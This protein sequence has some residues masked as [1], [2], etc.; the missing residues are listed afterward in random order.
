[1]SD[2]SQAITRSGALLA[3]F[4][5]LTALLVAGTFVGTRD[6]ISAAERAAE[7]KALLQIMPRSLHDNS[8]LD[9]RIA[10]PAGDP[11][12][13]LP[14]ER[15]LYVARQGGVASAVLVPAVAPDGY[16]G[17]IDLLVG[18]WRDGR[19]A[20]VR[21]LRH[22]ETPGLGDA[23]D[24]RKSNWVDG[25]VDRSLS[26]PPAERWTVRRDGGDFDQFT[27]ATI[28]PRAVVQATAR[29]LSYVA[30]NHDSIFNAGAGDEAAA[31]GDDRVSG[32]AAAVRSEELA[33]A[34]TGSATM[35]PRAA[36]GADS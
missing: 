26:D 31:Q 15:E 24:H 4:A 20:G 12:L 21:V 25:F 14:E 16:S 17:S 6:R 28:T 8:M 35:S 18:V 30:N 10:L 11:L 32:T 19:V 22:R 23:I 33:E 1:M 5:A 2:L 7:E 29:V 27:G 9:D 34:P 13:R 36:G 3:G